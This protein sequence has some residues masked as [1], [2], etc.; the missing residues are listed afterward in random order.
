[1]K[2]KL[3]SFG[4]IAIA[5]VGPFPGLAPCFPQPRLRATYVKEPLRTT[6]AIRRKI[7]AFN[8]QLSTLPHDSLTGGWTMAVHGK[9]TQKNIMFIINHLR[10]H[11]D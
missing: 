10:N 9:N 5:F 2:I 6:L 1:L 8:F 4:K 11:P 3:G 7:S